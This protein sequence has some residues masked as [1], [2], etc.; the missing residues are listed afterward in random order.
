MRPDP[1]S[2]GNYVCPLCDF[3]LARVL[4][5]QASRGQNIRCTVC[6]SYQAH[7]S[8]CQVLMWHNTQALRQRNTLNG[9][10]AHSSHLPHTAQHKRQSCAWSRPCLLV[11]QCQCNDNC[12]AHTGT[13]SAVP[14]LF[15][16]HTIL[17]R[18]EGSAPLGMTMQQAP[19]KS[20]GRCPQVKAAMRS[21]SYFAKN[22]K[23]CMLESTCSHV[24]GVQSHSKPF[25]EPNHVL[26]C[27][28]LTMLVRGS[29]WPAM[30]H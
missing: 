7:Q 1:G 18:S 6:G 30:C 13:P 4:H 17:N 3:A 22:G 9:G 11:V 8:Y 20:G 19:A 5:N 28:Q 14:P 25:L 16:T 29:E 23:S 12:V 10:K 21:G 24:H 2:A 26:V 27:D 15:A